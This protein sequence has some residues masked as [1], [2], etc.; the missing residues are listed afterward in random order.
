MPGE[1]TKK[2]GEKDQKQGQHSGQSDRQNRQPQQREQHSP[3]GQ[4]RPQSGQSNQQAGRESVTQHAGGGRQGGSLG[5]R[6]TQQTG[7]TGPN[8]GESET[9]GQVGGPGPHGSSDPE[10][11]ERN[12]NKPLTDDWGKG[13]KH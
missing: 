10:T 13:D 8:R 6:G 7:Q 9:A 1:S 4:S 11:N 2:Q 12:K 3:Q 5:Q